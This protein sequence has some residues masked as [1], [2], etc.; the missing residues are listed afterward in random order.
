MEYSKSIFAKLNELRQLIKLHSQG[1]PLPKIKNSSSKFVSKKQAYDDFSS[2]LSEYENILTNSYDDYYDNSE[3][4]SDIPFNPQFQPSNHKQLQNS[5]KNS[6]KP[7]SNLSVHRDLLKKINNEL[8][9]LDSQIEASLSPK[10]AK[11]GL[12]TNFY[13]P[14]K[15]QL[16]NSRTATPKSDNSSTPKAKTLHNKEKSPMNDNIKFEET[17]TKSSPTNIDVNEI[18][19]KVEQAVEEIDSGNNSLNTLEEDVNFN[20]NKVYNSPPHVKLDLLKPPKP[21]EI[22]EQPQ[23]NNDNDISTSSSDDEEMKRKLQMNNE[24]SSS[25]EFSIELESNSSDIT[26]TIND[27]PRKQKIVPKAETLTPIISSESEKEQEKQTPQDLYQPYANYIN[28]SEDE[29]LL[30]SPHSEPPKVS[31]IKK[32]PEFIE[33]IFSSSEENK[34]ELNDDDKQLFLEF[35]ELELLNGIESSNSSQGSG[36][37]YQNISDDLQNREIQAQLSI[38]DSLEED[39]ENQKKSKPKKNEPLLYS[40]SSNEND[41]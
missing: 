7:T 23:V 15:N 9:E 38:D 1:K 31:K 14:S 19:E 35:D 34:Q 24:K 25:S 3:E 20:E 12:P 32:E 10:S 33:P 11:S 29:D 18:I 13:S 40:C 4:Y 39:H 22:K 26:G 2:L 36:F 8:K 30:D 21:T 27:S 5:I 17:I 16:R 28:Q 37:H 6:P 41:N